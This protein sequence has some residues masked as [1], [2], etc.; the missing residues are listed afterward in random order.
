MRIPV[1]VLFSAVLALSACQSRWNPANWWDKDTTAAD[2]VNPLIPDQ[3]EDGQSFF[4]AKETEEYR[5]LPID[6]VTSVEVHRVTEGRLIMAIGVASV[7]GT[8]NVRLMLPK[9]GGLEGGVLTLNLMGRPPIEPIVGGS[10]QT[11][12]VTTAV[13][14]TAQQ[15]AGVRTIRVKALSNSID[16]RIR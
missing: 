9:E 10:D 3:T 11:R 13:V 15:M 12:E 4:A 14:L 16:R 6:K 2:A 1:L 7:H 5:G 8:S